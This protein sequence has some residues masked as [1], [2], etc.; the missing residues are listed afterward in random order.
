[1][2]LHRGVFLPFWPLLLSKIVK[3]ASKIVK[4]HKKSQK[5]CT[6]RQIDKSEIWC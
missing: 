2:H 5:V 4:L 3:R 6:I 1:M